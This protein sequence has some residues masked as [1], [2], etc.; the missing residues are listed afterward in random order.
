MQGLLNKPCRVQVSYC[1]STG[2]TR[3]TYRLQNN[4]CRVQV[5]YCISTGDTRTMYRLQVSFLQVFGC[6]QPHCHVL[7]CMYCS[8]RVSYATCRGELE[9]VTVGSPNHLLYQMCATEGVQ[10]IGLNIL[11]KT[12]HYNTT[13]LINKQLNLMD[14]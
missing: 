6:A 10:F 8:C 3:K 7:D 13:S 5:S 9:A 11:G 1:K 12:L 2:D 14:T 4:P